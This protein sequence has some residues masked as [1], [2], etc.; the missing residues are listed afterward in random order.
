MLAMT[1]VIDVRADVVE[2]QIN[3]SILQSGS[4]LLT[5]DT[6]HSAE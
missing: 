2:V 5:A 3:L 4:G 1:T 6:K